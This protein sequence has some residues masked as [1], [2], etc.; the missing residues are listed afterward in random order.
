MYLDNNNNKAYPTADSLLY[1]SSDLIYFVFMRNSPTDFVLL[2]LGAAA[3]QSSSYFKATLYLDMYSN[4]FNN[5]NG[6]HAAA[7]SIY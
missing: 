1:D 2:A 3:A 7:H 4:C 5:N 6:G